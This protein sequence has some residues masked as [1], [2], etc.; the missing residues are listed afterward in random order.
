MSDPILR[1]LCESEIKWLNLLR[2][3]IKDEEATARGFAKDVDVKE[4]FKGQASGF[5]VSAAYIQG[6]INALE[7]MRK[8]AA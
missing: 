5:E 1:Q 6:V 4:F 8:E 3:L 7:K 2:D